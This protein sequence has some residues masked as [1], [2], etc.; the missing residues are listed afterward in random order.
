MS[1][2]VNQFNREQTKRSLNIVAKW[3]HALNAG[4]DIRSV[5]SEI[6]DL[7]NA[8]GAQ[9]VRQMRCTDTTRM[10]TRHDCSASKL[11]ASPTR[12]YIS[13]V[14]GDDI[15]RARSGSIWLLSE[16]YPRRKAEDCLD[17]VGLKEVTLLALGSCDEYSD[18]LE[19]LH[20]ATLQNNDR[21]LLELMGPIISQCWEKR[22]PDLVEALLAGC[23]FSVGQESKPSTRILSLENPFKLTRSEYRICSMIQE[24]NMPDQIS[25]AL[26][27]KTST[28]RSHMR[29]I[30]QKTGSSSQLALVH[31]LR[32]ITND[33]LMAC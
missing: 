12:S 14:V 13:L 2:L 3:V 21:M 31:R 29:S 16:V 6:C 32:N 25:G 20:P 27:V 9:V 28:L 19:L 5:L 8:D 24:G 33:E 30:Y 1:K 11:F 17:Q 7:M 22:A 15:H 23:P 10:V 4:S 18:F 26:K